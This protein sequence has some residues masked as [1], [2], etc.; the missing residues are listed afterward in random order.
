MIVWLY[1][2]ISL[3]IVTYASSY[4][5]K[6]YENYGFA[7]LTAFYT[8]YLG[9][10]QIIASRIINFDLGF[11]QF[12]APAAVFIYPFIAQAI[13]MINEAY[14]K[15]KAHLAIFI[16][17]ITQVLLVTFIAMVNS[18]SPAPFFQFEEAWQNLFG[19]SLR[20]TVA[21]WIAFLICQNLDAHVF[22]WLKKKYEKNIV[23]RSLTSDVLDLTLDS[24]IFVTIAFYGVMPIELLIA[25]QIISKNIIGFLDTPWFVWYK[26]MLSWKKISLIPRRFL[27][28]LRG[29]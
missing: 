4:I 25:G 10:S 12:F 1:W 5:V 19:L 11:Y 6:K 17:F 21:S 26:K 9:A 14:G 7:A 29:K 27:E 18:L 8:I 23:L 2:A 13:D 22:A 15:A 20:I 28:R 16:A 24:I 3:T